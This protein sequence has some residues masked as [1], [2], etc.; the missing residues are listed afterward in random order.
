MGKEKPK[1]IYEIH[2]TKCEW[3]INL[4]EKQEKS[5]RTKEKSVINIKI[6]KCL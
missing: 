3:E 2:T 6:K 4:E 1:S 5:C